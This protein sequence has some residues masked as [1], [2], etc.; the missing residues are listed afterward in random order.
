MPRLGSTA[1][2]Y[3]TAAHHHRHRARALKSRMEICQNR[4]PERD[5]SFPA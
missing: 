2:G 5:R 3:T 4:G 1:G